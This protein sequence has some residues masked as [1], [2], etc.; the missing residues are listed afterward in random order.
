[1]R[2]LFLF[3]SLFASITA[4]ADE[5]EVTPASLSLA[6]SEAK[7][8]DVL[9]LAGGTYANKLT[10]PSGKTITLQAAEGDTVTLTGGVSSKD[11][12]ITDGGLVFEGVIINPNN[13]Y[14]LD[15]SACGDIKEITFRNCEIKNVNRCLLRTSTAGKTIDAITFSECLIHDC[16]LNGWN[17][18]YPTH[19]VKSV[20]VDNST[21]YNYSNGEGFFTPKNAYD[22]DF[23]FEFRHNTVYNWSKAAKYAICNVDSK[24]TG[25]ASYMF[26]D[27]IFYN[28]GT[29]NDRPYALKAS[30]GSLIA[31]KNLFINYGT[32]SHK[33]PE[34]QEIEDYT[35]AD[36]GLS[37]LVY[38]D[39]DN[40]NFYISSASDL[41]T[42]SS[43]GDVI[44]DTRWLKSISDMVHLDNANMPA[45]AG[46]I[47]P[48][49]A[50]Y[51]RGDSV[52]I[53]A[54][55]NYGYLFK[56]WQD[57]N[58]NT[59]S[60]DNPYIYVVEEN[61]T[62]TA[63]YE[64]LT[65]HSFTVEK[66]GD[67][68]EWGEVSLSP[69]PVD[70]KYVDGTV[71]TVS[72]VPNKVTS[73]LYW[74][75]LT[76]TSQ[77]IITIN[78]DMTIK[79]TFDV[80]PF[81]T[82]WNFTVSDP[83][84]KRPGDFYAETDNK[85][86]ISL[87]NSDGS[88]SNWGASVRNYDGGNYSC[89]RRYTGYS[90]MSDPRSFVAKF[91]SR[92]YKDLTV[93]FLAAA[94]N[95]CVHRIQKVQYSL[96]GTTYTDVASFEITRKNLWMEQNVA[97]PADIPTDT[98]VYVRWIGDTTS[99]LIG[100]P[101]DNATEGF[102]LTEVIIYG[103]EDSATDTE[104]PKLLSS[105]PAQSSST[106]SASGNIVLTFNKKIKQGTGDI[107]LNGNKLTGVYASK[108]V[109]FAYTGMDYG[110][111]CTFTLPAGAI[112]DKVGNT[113][114]GLT[115]TFNIMARP[116]PAAKL[117][118]AVVAADS[119]GDYATVQAAIDAAPDNLSYPYL[120][121]VKNGVYD[122]LV[123]VSQQKT[124]I[125]LI[126]QDKENTVI[127]HY[128]MC[129]D[130]TKAGSNANPSDPNYG[131]HAAVE[132]NG[133]DFYTENIDYV[134]SYGVDTQNGPM[135]LVW[136]TNADRLT[137]Y[138]CKMRS[139]QDT[140]ETSTKNQSDRHY[141]KNCHIEG[142]VDYLYGGGNVYLDSCTMYNMRAGSV[143]VAPCHRTSE[144]GYVFESCT[145]DGNN[146][147]KTGTCALGRPWHNNPKAVFLNTTAINEISPN[148]WNNMG[149]IPALFAEYNT[150]DANGNPVDL[151][152]RRTEYEYTDGTDSLGNPLKV[153]GSCKAVLTA[154][155]VAKYTYENVMSGDD[156]WNP[157]ML[158]EP[159]DAPTDIKWYQDINRLTWKASDY[160]ICYIVFDAED[161]VLSITKG[162]EY[163]VEQGK[164]PAYIKAVNENGSLS[165]KYDVSMYTSISQIDANVEAVR[166]EYYTLDGS[167]TAKD[168]TGLTILKTYY[169]D[170]SVRVQKVIK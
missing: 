22:G 120:I 47:T 6:Y 164:T 21:L 68:A 49:G 11:E 150:M 124:N 60:T 102:Y 81:I 65:T 75:D 45:E 103:E 26:Y 130:A 35:L 2:K 94:D 17:L 166:S 4:W 115:L 148:G 72:I 135:A 36:F 14:F 24:K 3:L 79:A 118:D 7:D 40:G 158:M 154:D 77:R 169:N 54:N 74:E 125:H 55:A 123:T 159:V 37:E 132:I 119:T 64:T 140:W 83:R 69:E 92:K 113:F 152:N 71:V 134:N 168:H 48:V 20:S 93:H 100:T 138:N 76:S 23:T 56:E 101:A 136:R 129:D 50:D 80:I 5:T 13:N 42:A 33:S 153:T 96:D 107:T 126:G 141:V 87:Y 34:E 167:K 156:R 89:I 46:Y 157:R 30:G 146:L 147:A 51:E 160:A 85:G 9:V 70:G 145:I 105:S 28:G 52:L 98:T 78:G 121:F 84:S 53:T 116:R 57:E 90:T 61:A 144:F 25:N 133:S 97:L 99:E 58:G 104:A 63:V 117:F 31:L 151:S 38:P 122:E 27:N 8:G 106:A 15:L 18:L 88:Q 155:E 39:P 127:K 149:A 43:D 163:S 32:Y 112:V 67:G 82:G 19:M 91:D 108:T 161:N 29:E 111:A 41:A 137:A 12:A 1:M 66:E 128:I 95:D 165:Q 142:A 110:Q 10:F 131:R 73:F 139:F 86:I 170:G 44:G 16:G 143:I 162:T 59:L 62:V 114:E 109:S